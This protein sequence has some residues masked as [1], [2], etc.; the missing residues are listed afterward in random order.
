MCIYIYIC[1]DTSLIVGIKA[2]LNG[3]I[4][5]TIGEGI[6]A[7]KSR[8]F[9]LT[10]YL[11][12]LNFCLPPYMELQLIPGHVCSFSNTRLRGT[13]EGGKSKTVPI[14]SSKTSIN[15]SRE[16][17]RVQERWLYRGREGVVLG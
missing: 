8:V 2:D 13:F 15:V 14:F 5:R 12:V 7:L 10:D 6:K 17:M 9:S 11:Q 3:D 1:I 16:N 4:R